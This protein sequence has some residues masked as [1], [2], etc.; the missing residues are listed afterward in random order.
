MAKVI[1]DSIAKFVLVLE[2]FFLLYLVLT[3]PKPGSTDVG[4]REAHLH[5][6]R[7]DTIE[8]RNVAE[9]ITNAVEFFPLGD[10]PQGNPCPPGDEI[11]PSKSKIQGRPS[12][13][14]VLAAIRVVAS[15]FS[16][17]P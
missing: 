2:I 10:G 4:S 16:R 6:V 9:A 14:R 11:W 15:N 8:P 3:V 12:R 5:T 13:S 1:G 7:L 17:C